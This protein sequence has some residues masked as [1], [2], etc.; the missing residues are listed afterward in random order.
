VKNSHDKL[1]LF[2]L[3][4]KCVSKSLKILTKQLELTFDVKPF[5]LFRLIKII[6]WSLR[7]WIKQWKVIDFLKREYIYKNTLYNMIT[8][9]KRSNLIIVWNNW[10]SIFFQPR[11]PYYCL[12]W[13]CFK[14]KTNIISNQSIQYSWQVLPAFIFF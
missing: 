4:I 14:I 2:K 12:N 9:I 13:K 8:D 3:K 6:H 7:K 11:V 5:S 10:N 1:D